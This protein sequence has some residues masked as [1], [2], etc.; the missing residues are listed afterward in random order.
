[1]KGLIAERYHEMTYSKEEL[2]RRN[3]AYYETHRDEMLAKSKR[4]HQKRM[5]D[6]GQAYNAQQRRW[7]GDLRMAVLEALGLKCVKCGFSDV[8]ALV[9]DHVN[10]GGRKERD[11]Y[12]AVYKYYK[13]IL[14]NV[15]SGKYQILCANCNTIKMFEEK[16]HLTAKQ[17]RDLDS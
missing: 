9:I 7:Y 1:V 8:R 14:E 16:E 3:K 4:Q 17:L 6:G 13:H 12:N 11:T 10:G 5:A 15:D 2:S